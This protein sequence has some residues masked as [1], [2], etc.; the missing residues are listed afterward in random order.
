MNIKAMKYYSA[1]SLKKVIF[2]RHAQT[3]LIFQA[4]LFSKSFSQHP[5]WI[6]YPILKLTLYLLA[7]TLTKNHALRVF[8]VFSLPLILRVCLVPPFKKL[9]LIMV[10][11]FEN[12]SCYLNLVFFCVLYVFFFF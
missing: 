4:S 6:L 10:C 1:L 3:Q 5:Y 7:K 9:F 8:L 12:C 11:K 2:S